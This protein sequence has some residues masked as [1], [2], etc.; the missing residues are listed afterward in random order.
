[1]IDEGDI[2]LWKSYIPTSVFLVERQACFFS[3]FIRIVLTSK[4]GT[5]QN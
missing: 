3:M 4:D 1:M 5:N 2:S